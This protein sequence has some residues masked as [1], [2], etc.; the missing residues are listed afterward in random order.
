MKCVC[1]NPLLLTPDGASVSSY[2]IKPFTDFD[3]F[4][5]CSRLTLLSVGSGRRPVCFPV[6]LRAVAVL[7]PSIWTSLIFFPAALVQIRQPFFFFFN[8]ALNIVCALR[9]VFNISLHTTA[10]F[11]KTCKDW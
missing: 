6:L 8:F 11:D 7:D 10:H 9:N 4:L 2:S 3:S 1:N 5:S